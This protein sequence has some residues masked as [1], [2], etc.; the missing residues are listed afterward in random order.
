[1]EPGVS[2][3]TFKTKALEIMREVETS[4]KRLIITDRGKP[5]LTIDRYRCKATSPLDLLKGSVLSYDPTAPVCEDD[6][7][8]GH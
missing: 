4:G 5:T 7:E 1:M 3:S 8:I 2:K 6:W